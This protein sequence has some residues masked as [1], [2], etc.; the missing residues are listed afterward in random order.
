MQIYFLNTIHMIVQLIFKK[1]LNRCLDQFIIYYKTNLLPFENTL[2][3]IL[4][5]IS[6]DIPSLQQAYLSSM[7]R[8]K[9]V[10][11]GCV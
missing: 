6:F 4:P 1:V 8:R 5:R 11:F 7:S 10:H 3:K 2:M 9:M